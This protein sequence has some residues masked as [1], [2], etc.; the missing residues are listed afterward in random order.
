MASLRKLLAEKQRIIAPGVFDSLSAKAV[1]EAGFPA[2]Y[3]TGW[4]ASG[5]RVGEPDLGLIS[6][7]EVAD[8]IR[9]ITLCTNV[10]IIAD[11]DTGYG[12]P[13][14]VARTVRSFELAGAA[15]VQIEDQLWPKRCGHVGGKILIPAEEMAAKIQ[16]AVEAKKNPETLIVARTDAIAVEGYDKAV[17]RA[18]LYRKAGADI[19]FVE[20]IETLEQ[21][22]EVPK[23]LPGWQLF[24]N[25]EGGKSPK[26]PDDEVFDMGYQ[27]VIHPVML[28][29]IVAKT[30]R[31]SLKK[32]KEARNSEPFFK[33][34]L[35]FEQFCDFIG[36]TKGK[37][38]DNQ[39][40]AKTLEWLKN[41]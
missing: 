38:F 10:P 33:D 32:L 12:G 36:M 29:F 35:T 18:E 8:V 37:D 5:S 19:L 20:A 13:L 24:N 4:G 23:I 2:C 21:L 31:D 7:S 16:A 17:K 14:C 6:G 30:L 40:L 11:A 28:I 34:M 9:N 3:L 15:A 22:K 25:V 39:C 41:K 26:L 27:I 1:D